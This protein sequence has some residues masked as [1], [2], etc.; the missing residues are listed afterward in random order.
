MSNCSDRPE[1]TDT[2]YGQCPH[3][4]AHAQVFD[5]ART[6]R[7][8]NLRSFGCE[9]ALVQSQVH[10]AVGLRGLPISTFLS[11]SLM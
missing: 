9:T 6:I 3:S 8:I 11:P 4:I 5:D 10:G 1:F 7:R 2:L